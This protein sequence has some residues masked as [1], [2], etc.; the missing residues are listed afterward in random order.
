MNCKGKCKSLKCSGENMQFF[1]PGQNISDL[2]ILCLPF[3]GRGGGKRCLPK[4]LKYFLWDCVALDS[5][6]NYWTMDTDAS[7][8]KK[9]RHFYKEAVA[10]KTKKQQH[11][12]LNVRRSAFTQPIH[13]VPL[14]G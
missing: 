14:L 8:L 12:S 5:H 4:D 7:Q 10:K 13:F 2:F 1:L 6:S 3:W 11:S 9:G